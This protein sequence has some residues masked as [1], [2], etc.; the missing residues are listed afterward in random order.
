MD[1]DQELLILQLLLKDFYDMEDFIK[2]KE[3]AVKRI[4]ELK[5]RSKEEEGMEVLV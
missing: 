2:I 3:K 5:I 4:S 1:T